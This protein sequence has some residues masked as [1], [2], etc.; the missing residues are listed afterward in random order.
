[1]ANIKKKMMKNIKGNKEKD[2]KKYPVK[3]QISTIAIIILVM[4]AVAI[5]TI[6]VTNVAKGEYTFGKKNLYNEIIAGQVFNRRENEYYVVFYDDEEIKTSVLELDTK[7]KIY[8]VNLKEAFNKNIL[9]LSTNIKA[10]NI[11]E[12]KVYTNT[13]IKIKDKENVEQVTGNDEIKEYLEKIK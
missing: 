5:I 6:T 10:S 13:I 12:F 4:V 7:S 9:S 11:D 1:M 2:K 8:L 3:N